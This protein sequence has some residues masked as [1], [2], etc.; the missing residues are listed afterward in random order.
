MT[1]MI[2]ATETGTTML[3]VQDIMQTEVATVAPEMTIRELAQF[4]NRHRISGAPVCDA[5]GNVLGVV[6]A[7]D[8]VRL[9]AEE[10]TPP[11]DLEPLD[12]ALPPEEEEG[13]GEEAAWYYFLAREAPTLYTGAPVEIQ[14]EVIDEVTVRD[15]MTPMIFHVSP[16]ATVAELARFLLRGKIHRALVMA[17]NK[18][19]GIV[20]AFDVLRVVAEAP[21]FE[22]FD[23]AS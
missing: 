21:E 3:T 19:I 10:P 12:L 23:Y 22:E 17:G 14:E 8:L 4:W 5:S 6:S 20:T 11:D 13:E 9:A 2:P 1:A 15:I 18:L 7:T 16:Q